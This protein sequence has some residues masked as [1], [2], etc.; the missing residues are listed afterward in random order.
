MTAGWRKLDLPAARQ[1]AL[2]LTSHIPDY[3]LGAR[4][5]DVLA[6]QLRMLSLADAIESRGDVLRAIANAL[7]DQIEA[8]A[9]KRA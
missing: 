2:T 8:A 7:L 3:A 5:Y 6:E 1:A 9:W 4:F